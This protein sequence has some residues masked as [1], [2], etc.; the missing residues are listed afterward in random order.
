MKKIFIMFI[1]CLFFVCL[2]NAESVSAKSNIQI[3]KQLCKKFK[4][5]VKIISSNGNFVKTILH[6]KGKNYILVRKIVSYS[7]GKKYGWTKDG[8]YI[9]YNKKVPKHKKVVSYFIYN[10]KTNY[11]DDLL[12]IVDNNTYRQGI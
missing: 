5:P 7:S 1:M 9:G 10:P 11:F 6:R 2:Y 4:K 12:W 8:Q 3:V